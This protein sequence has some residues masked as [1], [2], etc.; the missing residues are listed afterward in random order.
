MVEVMG[1]PLP[2]AQCIA[3]RFR[4]AY[5]RWTYAWIRYKPRMQGREPRSLLFSPESKKVFGIQKPFFILSLKLSMST[6]AECLISSCIASMRSPKPRPA[7][8]ARAQSVARG[9]PIPKRLKMFSI[10]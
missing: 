8:I 2:L 10:R 9:V 3:R 7:R 1:Y 4:K 5:G 6:T